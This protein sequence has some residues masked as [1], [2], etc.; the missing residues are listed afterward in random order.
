MKTIKALL[1]ALVGASAVMSAGPATVVAKEASLRAVSCFPIGSPPG[2]PFEAVVK[3]INNR[4][5]GVVKIRLLGGAPAVGSPFTLTQRM[6]KGAFDMVG[7]TESYFGNVFPEAPVLRLQE[8][9]FAT[10][11]KNGGLDYAAKLMAAKNIH[12]VARHGDFGQFHLYLSK[13]ITGPNLKG[14]HLRVAPNYTAFFK[15]LGA[16]VQRAAMPQIYTLMENG[17]VQ[18]YGWP[19]G[20][21][22]PA[23]HKVTKYRVDP[24]FYHS[25][26]HTVANLRKWK[27]LSKAA[28]DIITKVGLEAEAKVEPYGPEAAK[29]IEQRRAWHAKGGIKTI[30]FKG[31]DAKKWSDAARDAAWGEVIERSPEHGPKLKALFTKAN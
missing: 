1:P 17:T 27:T 11:R 26:L 13:P 9:S 23:W 15:S 5:K 7:C 19:L 14:L 31:A 16:T 21:Y 24:G 20:G 3:E 25:S 12:Y 29:L 8:V 28:Q 4:G 22:A 2:R 6:A 30:T 18:G 10:L